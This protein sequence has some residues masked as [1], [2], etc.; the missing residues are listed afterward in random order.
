MRTGQKKTVFVHRMFYL[1]TV[2]EVIYDRLKLKS[3]IA[4]SALK[5]SE[6]EKEDKDVN[7]ALAI[8]PIF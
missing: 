7:R 1:G 4:Q 6:I 3:D 8:S 5:P 2:E